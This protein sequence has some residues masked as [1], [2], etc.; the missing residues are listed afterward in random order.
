MRKL[1]ALVTAAVLLAQATPPPALAAATPATPAKRPLGGDDFYNIQTLTDPEVAPDGRWVAYVV[2]TNDR[3]ADEPRSAIWMVSWDG[4]QRLPL[5]HAAHDTGTPRWSPDGRFLAYLATPPGSE[6]SQIMV[7]DRRGGEAT[8]LTHLDDDIQSYAWSPNSQRMVLVVDQGKAKSPTDTA[9]HTPGTPEPPTPIVID[10]VH[11]KEDKDGYPGAGHPRHLALL[12]IDS[13]RIEPLTSDATFTDSLAE[14]SPDGHRIAFIRTHDK[15]PDSDAMEDIDLIEAR[16]G[17]T[18][19]TLLR[20]FAPNT[21]KLAW[22]PD[23]TTLAYLQGPEAKYNQYGQDH[24]AVV[25]LGG[26]RTRALA[27]Q[28]DRAISSH[29]FARGGT[30]LVA[31]LEDD[32][33]AYAAQIDLRTGSLKPLARGAFVVTGLNSAAGHTAVLYSDDNSPAEVY[34][35]DGARPRKLTGHNDALMATLELGAVEDPRFPSADGTPLHGLLVKPPHFDAARKYPT[36]LY[37]HGGSNLP[38]SHSVAFDGYQFKRQLI[39]AAGF[40]VIGVNYRGSSGRGDEF[41]RSIA[42]DWGHKEVEDVLA[43]VDYAVHLGIADP[44]RLGIGGWSYGGMTTDYTIAATNRFK[45]AISGAGTANPLALYGADQYNLQYHTELGDPW[46]NTELYLK[47]AAP[48]LHAD[49]IHTPTLFMGGEKD[50]NVPLTGGDQLYLALRTL[51]VP[52]E[53]TIYPGAFHTLTRPR[54]LKDRLQRM[55]DWYRRY[56]LPAPATGA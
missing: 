12:D 42:A 51:G 28:V 23:G 40:V 19:S 9:G 47:L 31:T 45:A 37:I 41:A 14:W 50:F 5:T 29:A 8:A 15:G 53:L 54:Y 44:E 17:A 26:G 20:I 49:R 6:K 27:Q 55:T 30:T 34:A 32:T 2:T 39:A 4:T 25:T 33:I 22:G 38:D 24:L 43:G 21:Q 48:F 56:L 36:V 16:A 35:L 1:A 7:L 18:A 46:V 3:D 10:A 11:F 52:T 13:R